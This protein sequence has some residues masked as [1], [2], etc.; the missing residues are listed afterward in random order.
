MGAHKTMKATTSKRSSEIKHKL[1]FL[2]LV[3]GSFYEKITSAHEGTYLHTSILK[4][5]VHKQQKTLSVVLF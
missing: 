3:Y 5:S 1:L 2:P 4:T